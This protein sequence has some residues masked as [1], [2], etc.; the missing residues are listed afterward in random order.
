MASNPLWPAP[1]PDATCATCVWRHA[2]GR[3]RAAPR[4]RRHGNAT[5]QDHWPACPAHTAS[6]DCQACAACC[7]EAYHTVE[8]SRRDPFVRLHPD[9]LTREQGRWELKRVGGLCPCLDGAP[10][11]WTCEVYADRP[12]TCRDFEPAG[13]NCLDAR[14]RT[15]LTP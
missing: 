3:G 13:A 8:V 4:C 10:G 12:R 7:R 1:G 9:R 15:G 11:A 6:L 14:R 5:L 2:G